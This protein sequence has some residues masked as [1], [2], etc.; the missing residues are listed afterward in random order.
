MTVT[1]VRGHGPGKTTGS[2]IPDGLVDQLM[3]AAGERGTELTGPGGFLPELI[4]AV[5]ERGMQAELSEHLGYDKH[6]PIGRGSG[7]WC[8]G[9]SKK[10][11][12]NRDR[13][14]HVGGATGSGRQFRLPPGA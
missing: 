11:V 4:K 14:D 3:A 2:G 7:N 12:K 8:N 5:L 9:T 6:D 1:D 10:T 13:P